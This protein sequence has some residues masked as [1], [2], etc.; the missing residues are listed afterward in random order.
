M[1]RVLRAAA[2]AGQSSRAV[3]DMRLRIYSRVTGQS[4]YI[5]CFEGSGNSGSICEGSVLE[6]GV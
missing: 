1:S 6:N 5:T 4:I 2:A 3:L